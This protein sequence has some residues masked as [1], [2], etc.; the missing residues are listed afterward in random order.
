N[1]VLRGASQRSNNWTR[2]R[3]SYRLNRGKITVGGDG[4][5]R[6]DHI[7]PKAVELTRQAGLFL[8]IHAA[9]RRLLAIAQSR[10]ENRNS[11]ALHHKLPWII[12]FILGQSPLKEKL[13]VLSNIVNSSNII[14]FPNVTT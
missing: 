2:H 3:G 12:I 1:I 5:S 13:I 7:Y 4:E 6:L 14:R 10:V 8:H 11:I 9:A